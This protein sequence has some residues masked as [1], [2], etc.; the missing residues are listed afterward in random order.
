MGEKMRSLHIDLNT[1]STG[2]QLVPEAILKAYLG[3]R[4]LN[5]WWAQKLIKKEMDPLS[6]EN[7]LLISAGALTGT[8]ALSSSRV[9]MTA[10][11]PLTGLLA[12]SNVGGFWGVELVKKGIISL[13]I[14]GRAETPVYISITDTGVVIRSAEEYW[15]MDTREAADQIRQAL[16]DEKGYIAVIGPAGERLVRSAAVLFGE[17]DAAGR[18][19]LGAVL[20]SKNLK[21]IAVS[22]SK[23]PVRASRSQMDLAAEHARLVTEHDSF[24]EWHTFGDS[25]QVKWLDDFNAGPAYNYRQ[26][27]YEHVDSANGYRLAEAPTRYTTCYR[28]PVRCKAAITIPSGADQGFTGERPP[29][30]PM[31]AWGAKCGNPDVYTS[32][33]LHTLCNR[34]GMDSIETASLVAFAMDLSQ[35]GILSPEMTGGKI[36]EWGHVGQMKQLTEEIAFRSTWLGKTL[37]EGLTA[38]AIAI[39]P[40]AKAYAY[41]V[42]GMA[43]TSMD[44]RGFKGTGLGYCISSR[45]ADFSNPYPSLECGY[46]P[47]RSM[48]IFGDEG[49]GDRLNE[50]GKGRMVRYTAS[51]SAVLDSLGLCK[52]PYLS[53]LNDFTL[54]HPTALV[55]SVYGW[56]MDREKMIACGER[57]VTLERLVNI[58]LGLEPTMDRLPDK[59]RTEPMPA[60][61]CAGETVDDARMVMDFYRE[62]GWNQ[63]GEPTADTLEKLK[64]DL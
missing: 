2:Y 39:G 6:A 33:F 50:E 61:I 27:Q 21:A 17:G 57:V 42:K 19:G 34:W 26:P 37:G 15:G 46:N 62:M 23:K 36:L 5:A 53:I 28:C 14:T 43:M 13:V 9:Q 64:I 7:P 41:H 16:H 56:E 55:N 18:T 47:R 10:V 22:V 49:I 24:Q 32:V 8:A 29:F 52:I 3:G 1:M 59:F 25:G 4:G 31:A 38:A 11:S 35:R 63:N 45:G 20:G 30:E 60:G 58:R 44:P 51:V 40:E 54:V 48:E 12:N